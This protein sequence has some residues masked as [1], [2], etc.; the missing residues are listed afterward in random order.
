MLMRLHFPPD[1]TLT[2]PSPLLTLLWRPQ[3]IPPTP[4][5][6]PL[7]PNPLGHLPSLQSG[8]RSIGYGGLLAY[9]MNAIT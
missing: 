8:I 6:T 1:V 9:M 7:T 3:D 2:L 5:S 4:P